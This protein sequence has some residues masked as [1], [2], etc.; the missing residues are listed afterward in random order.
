MKGIWPVKGM[1]TRCDNS[2]V[3]LYW[4]SIPR[5]AVEIQFQR[6]GCVFRVTGIVTSIYI[7]TDNRALERCTADVMVVPAL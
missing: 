1:E 3:R 2:A 7:A 4:R 5:D 6:L